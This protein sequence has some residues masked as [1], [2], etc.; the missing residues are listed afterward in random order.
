MADQLEAYR[1]KRDFSVTSEPSGK[2]RGRKGKSLSFV[3]QKHAAT[4]LHYDFRLEL[5]GVLKSWAVTRGP[6][7]DPGDKRLAVHVE[8]HPIEYG[9][10]EG[11]IP[12]GEYGAGSVLLW[13]RGAWT[14]EG[15][16]HKG[17]AKGHLEFS[18]EGE[19]LHGR[20]HLV[21]MRGKPKEK[22]DNWLLIKADDEFATPGEGETILAEQP[23]SVET[24]RTIEEIG[25][26]KKSR[27]WHSNKPTH[28]A[29]PAKATSPKRRA[30]APLNDEA[31]PAKPTQTAGAKGARARKTAARRLE[32]E[33]PKGAKRATLPRFVEPELATL[34]A[35]PPVAENYLHRGEIR[36]LS[37]AGGS[38]EGKDGPAHAQGAGL[39]RALQA[40]R[41][42]NRRPARRETPCSMA[43]SSWKTATASRIS[44]R[45]KRRCATTRQT[46][47]PITSSICFISTGTT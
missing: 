42:G 39:D 45:F 28:G 33:F 29:A 43:R 10:F 4:R 11:T 46:R 24:Q 30:A 2:A 35:A 19:K 36:R 21:R 38:A 14:P 18:L 16:P 25:G 31:A 17:Y 15:D 26:D 23:R 37:H 32:F 27:R 9:S 1:K 34:S 5:D 44:P 40:D 47:S 3:I 22:A 6:S 8:D 41:R 13:D 7:L 20:W 12:A